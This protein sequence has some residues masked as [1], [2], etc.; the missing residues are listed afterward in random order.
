MVLVCV[1]LPLTAFLLWSR[2]QGLTSFLTR[3]AESRSR[4]TQETP[5]PG[6][7]LASPAPALSAAPDP[8]L[9]ALVAALPVSAVMPGDP[10][11]IML[12]G[13]IIRAGEVADAGLIFRDI[14]DGQLHFTDAQGRIYSRHY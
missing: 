10:D 5:R 6:P 7:A 8:G 14:S 9:A 4:T 12:N 2:L 1:L 3:P 11:R 13:H